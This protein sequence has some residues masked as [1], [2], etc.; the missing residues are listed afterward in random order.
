M[1]KQLLMGLTTLSLFVTLAA[2]SAS[3]QSDM[4]LKVN[5]PF[6]FSVGNEV[7][8][9]GEYTVRNMVQATLV[10]RSVDRS[11][12]QIFFDDWHYSQHETK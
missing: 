11:A 9:A 1:K 3:A 5:I 10:I 2:V 6:E 7:L 8:P 4:S 12:S